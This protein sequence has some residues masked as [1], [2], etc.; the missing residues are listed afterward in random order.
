MQKNPQ[1]VFP[2]NP[3]LDE[4]MTAQTVNTRDNPTLKS[5]FSAQQENSLSA[6]KKG[7]SNINDIYS[8]KGF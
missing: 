5:N 8:R 3:T 2:E 4:N 6:V 7:K 1:Y